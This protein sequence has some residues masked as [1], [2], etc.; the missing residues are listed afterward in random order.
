[1]RRF[2]ATADKYQAK[3][4]IKSG[5]PTF[6]RK[7][8]QVKAERAPVQTACKVLDLERMSVLEQ[9]FQAMR[10]EPPQSL[11]SGAVIA[12][13]EKIKRAERERVYN[14]KLFTW[15]VDL[16]GAWAKKV[17]NTA[18]PANFGFKLQNLPPS[19]RMYYANLT[20][21][22]SVMGE[23]PQALFSPALPTPEYRTCQ[24]RYKSWDYMPTCELPPTDDISIKAMRDARQYPRDTSERM[25]ESYEAAYRSHR[26]KLHAATVQA[27]HEVVAAKFELLGQGASRTTYA[28]SKHTVLKV[29]NRAC[30][31]NFGANWNEI[32]LWRKYRRRDVIKLA[33]CRRV[34]ILGVPCLIM[35][36]VTLPGKRVDRGSTHSSEAP[37][38]AGRLDLYQCAL[39]S[40]GEWVAYDY[41]YQFEDD[42]S[43]PWSDHELAQLKR[44]GV[45]ACP[46][47]AQVEAAE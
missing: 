12:L 5:G 40:R 24:E 42:I 33:A 47:P 41:G 3:A 6:G 4:Q 18:K 1:M 8:V 38:W 34:M 25:R 29:P 26:I 35:Q 21:I 28:L 19:T 2:A 14:F 39:T 11:M 10:R 7:A 23:P 9:A 44:R 32:R 17:R 13:E 16:K 43:R 27:L 22:N 45:Q 20:G 37:V 30:T 36:R 31:D 15:D 46:A